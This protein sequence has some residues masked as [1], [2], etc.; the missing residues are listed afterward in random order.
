[1]TGKALL[2]GV[3]EDVSRGDGHVSG[4]RKTPLSV[5]G[6]RPIDWG[7]SWDKQVE[8]GILTFSFS[9]SLSVSVSVPHFLSGTLSEDIVSW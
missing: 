1:M 8:G 3:C 9:L 6:H 2:L 4:P 5:D 7:R